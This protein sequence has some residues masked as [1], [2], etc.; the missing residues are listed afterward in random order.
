MDASKLI[1][2]L[3]EDVW[4]I[5]KAV[6]TANRDFPYHD[7]TSIADG[8]EPKNYVVGTN[9]RNANGDQQKTFVS[10]STLI[11]SDVECTVRFNDT[12]NVAQ[13]ILADTC[14]EF[15]S[16]IKNVYVSA[17]ATDGTIYMYFEGVLPQETRD[18]E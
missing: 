8:E 3:G 5:I 12:G 16:N 9:N 10:K 18:A 14:Y 13:T 2:K 4:N 17:I 11:I 7:F 15:K 6:F 1:K